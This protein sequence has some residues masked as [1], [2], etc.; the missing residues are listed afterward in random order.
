M[1]EKGK[2]KPIVIVIILIIVVIA[3]YGL[4]KLN[5]DDNNTTDNNIN[6]KA[7][8]KTDEN[9]ILRNIIDNGENVVAVNASN[10]EKVADPNQEIDKN[11]MHK[12]ESNQ[13][14][15]ISIAKEEWGNDSNVEFTFD[16]IDDKGRYI[17]FIRDINTTRQI[18]EYIV[19]IN[20]GK[21]VN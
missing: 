1:S 7:E 6:N 9:E 18:D 8:N 10:N 15:A 17:I 21:V 11:E 4:I 14:K 16:H 20:L 12:Q 5:K 13:E 19:D 2:S 3:C